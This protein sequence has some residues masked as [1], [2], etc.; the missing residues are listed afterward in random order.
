MKSSK[1][2]TILIITTVT[3][4]FVISI[5]YIGYEKNYG[6][7][8]KKQMSID[9]IVSSYSYIYENFDVQINH[10]FIGV[11]DENYYLE[12]SGIIKNKSKHFLNEIEIISD[13]SVELDGN[14][15]DIDFEHFHILKYDEKLN[16]NQ[17]IKFSKKLYFKKFNPDFL[18]YKV[19][20]A[21]LKVT[22]NGSNSV[23]YKISDN[24]HVA[25]YRSEYDVTESWKSIS[26]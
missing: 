4:L 23:G 21:T 5:D 7:Y 3:I 2:L 25:Y 1:S 8:N 12:F 15:V 18:N 13:L 10:A 20:K 11:E 24:A 6:F 9:K 26:K 19:I 16:A 17:S 22:L 14:Y